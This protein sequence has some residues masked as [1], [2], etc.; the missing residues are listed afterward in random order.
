VQQQPPPELVGAAVGE[1]QRVVGE[2]VLGRVARGV[3]VLGE[4]LDGGLLFDVFFCRVF[5]SSL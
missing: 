4:E 2:E 5:F 1:A 3:D